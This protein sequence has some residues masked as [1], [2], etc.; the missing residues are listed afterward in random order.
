MRSFVKKRKEGT[1]SVAVRLSSEHCFRTSDQTFQKTAEHKKDEEVRIKN[2]NKN[3]PSITYKIQGEGRWNA[4]K[5][6]FEY[7][8]HLD[9]KAYNDGEWVLEKKLQDDL[10][11]DQL[12]S[13]ISDIK[14]GLLKRLQQ[15]GICMSKGGGVANRSEVHA[16]NT[17]KLK[18]LLGERASSTPISDTCMSGREEAISCLWLLDT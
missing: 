1:P 6:D 18:I 2:L 16:W 7:Q 13:F 11:G 17:F 3:H 15:P 8:L 14:I 9:G 10:R 5:Q 4:Q 12:G